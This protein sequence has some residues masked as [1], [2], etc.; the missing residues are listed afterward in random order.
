[1]KS[2]IALFVFLYPL[3]IS[4]Q[5]L[6]EKMGA[7]SSEFEFYSDTTKLDIRSQILMK[8]ALAKSSY[9]IEENASYG[10]AYA[11]TEWCLEFVSNSK[12]RSVARKFRNNLKADTYSITFLNEAGAILFSKINSK[13]HVRSWIG[14][15][16]SKPIYTYSLNLSSLPLVL[17]DDISRIEIFYVTR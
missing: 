4:A 13:G 11:Y 6:T 5:S 17:M 12:I 14:E 8:R 3:F 9:S 15:I 10:Y 16:E 1:M 2:F 7:I